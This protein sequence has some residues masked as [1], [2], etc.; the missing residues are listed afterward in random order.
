MIKS[1]LGFA[2][3]V[4]VMAAAQALISSVPA[5]AMGYDSLSCD[6]LWSRRTEI[7]HRSGFC[8][9]TEREMKTYSNEKCRF[10]VEAEVP[11]SQDER[12]DFDMIVIAEKRKQC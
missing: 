6:E 12:K 8:F 2:G 9:T 10:K 11:L 7:L 4:I 1:S 5:H 3:A